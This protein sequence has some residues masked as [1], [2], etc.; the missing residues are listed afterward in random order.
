MHCQLLIHGLECRLAIVHHCPE[1]RAGNTHFRAF[2]SLV[3]SNKNKL[4]SQHLFCEDTF[5]FLEKVPLTLIFKKSEFS[6][7]CLPV[8]KFF[9][10]GEVIVTI[11]LHSCCPVGL[12]VLQVPRHSPLPG[13]LQRTACRETAAGG[14]VHKG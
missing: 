11:P 13:R 10:G 6:A 5:L 8:E 9:P 1:I 3:I 14:S 7:Q 4:T 2:I 12:G